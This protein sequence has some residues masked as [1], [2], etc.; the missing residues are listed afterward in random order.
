MA[1]PTRRPVKEPG[2]SPTAIRSTALPA[3]GRLGAALDL[4][5]QP[6]RVQRPAALGEPELRL[7]DDLAVAPGA[8]GGVGG[9]GVEADDDQE[10]RPRPYFTRKTEVPTFLP[11][12]NQ[13]TDDGPGSS[14]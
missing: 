7:G 5:E 14:R 6:G 4:G 8:G 13:V 10:V 11:L 3:A 9:R 2:P 12:T 1:I